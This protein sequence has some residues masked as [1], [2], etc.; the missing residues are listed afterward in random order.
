MARRLQLQVREEIGLSCSLG[1]A[2]NKL[3][4]KVASDHDKP[5][6]L[7]VVAPGEE[8]AFLAPLPVRV[9]WGVGPVTAQKLAEMGVTTVGELAGVTEETL[10]A[11]LG[12]HGG[13]MARQAR[14][15]E[16]GVTRPL[17]RGL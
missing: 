6:G 7:T 10:C 2:T 13:D 4:A 12:R 11:R 1:V 3:V 17:L 15:I 5:G 8:A 16:D 14:G 9:L